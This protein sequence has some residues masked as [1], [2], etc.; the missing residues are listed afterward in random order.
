MHSV[1]KYELQNNIT[2]ASSALF[3]WVCNT[4]EDAS[5]IF[6]FSL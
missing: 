1:T 4:C 5:Q 6:G 2:A 3:T